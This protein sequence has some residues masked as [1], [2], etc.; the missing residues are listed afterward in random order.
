MDCVNLTWFMNE[1]IQTSMFCC[2]IMFVAVNYWTSCFIPCSYDINC[3]MLLMAH[4]TVRLNWG[5]ICNYVSNQSSRSRKKQNWNTAT[6]TF[7]SICGKLAKQKSCL[8]SLVIIAPMLFEI[9]R[10]DSDVQRCS[11]LLQRLK[12]V[13]V[14]KNNEHSKT[15]CK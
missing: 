10:I 14:I 8:A 2:V 6:H 9:K 11:C 5:L 1:L 15:E 3:Q 4:V 7:L 12:F 13:C